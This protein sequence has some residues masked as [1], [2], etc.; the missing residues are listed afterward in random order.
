VNTVATVSRQN[1]GNL[2]I[3]PNMRMENQSM[4]RN[5]DNLEIAGRLAIPRKVN[6]IP[7]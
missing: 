2:A 6:A 1:S 7:G 4:R 3:E 5:G